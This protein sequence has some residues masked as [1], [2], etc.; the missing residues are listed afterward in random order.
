MLSTGVAGA[1]LTLALVH[2]ILWLLDRRNL[3]S[4]AFCVLAVSVAAMAFTE[5]GMMH[6]ASPAQ[7]G[8]WVRWFHLPNYFAIAG[9]VA[10]IHLQFGTGRPW[11]AA[12]IIALRSLLVITNFL[13]A[14]NVNW[15]EIVALE[16]IPFLGEEISV[17]GKAVA[18]PT[19]WLGMAASLLLV[20]YVVDAS[21]RLWQRG[22][23]EARRKV[24]IIGGG[25]LA[26]L[27]LA[28]AQ[29]QL[30][31]WQV[32]R[33]PV[34]VTPPFLILMLAMTYQL[35][36]DIVE[37]A[38]RS[39][40][41]QL[42]RRQLAH[43]SRV[44]VLGQLSGGI[45]HELRQPLTAILSN[46]QAAQHFLANKNADPQLLGEILQD[47]V[48]ADQRAVEIIRRL[49]T[50]FR[51]GESSFEALD[52]NGLARDVLR[53]VNSDL[54]VRGVQVAMDLEEP[55]APIE[56]DR[57]ELQQVLLNLVMNAC[58]AMAE[59]PEGE[60][61][62]VIRT[63]AGEAGQLQISVED[64]GPGFPAEQYERLFEPFYTTKQQGLGLGLSICRTI[65]RSHRGRLWGSSTADRGAVFHVLLPT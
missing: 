9:L 3:A 15:R 59:L 14:P 61:R 1:A 46:A 5:L 7:Y 43:L 44:S 57:V 27:V 2:G 22:D 21:L 55:L 42:Q 13:V 60:R 47:I 24:L 38:R 25:V 23:R 51:R 28:I 18:R 58:E 17:I 34:L 53:I 12:A 37:S 30:V 36:R 45:V 33:M 63:R 8:Q 39:R 32:L 31:V 65:V 19:A 52:V 50:L 49:Q 64:N 20:A 56:G 11:L 40:E 10:F 4:L 35:C 29:S 16:R 41:A 62:L 6:A 26:F 54:V 48:A